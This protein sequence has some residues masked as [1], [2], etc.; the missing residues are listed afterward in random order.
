MNAA[1]TNKE[2]AMAYNKSREAFAM[3]LI[4]VFEVSALSKLAETCLDEIEAR[5]SQLN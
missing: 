4:D 2:L 3:G 5:L 1:K